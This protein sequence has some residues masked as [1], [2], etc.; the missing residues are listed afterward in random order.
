MPHTVP[1]TN[2]TAGRIHNGQRIYGRS[3]AVFPGRNTGRVQCIEKVSEY[4][5]SR[6]LAA[7]PCG[8]YE[9][10]GEQIY[11]SIQEYETK[12]YMDC[13]FETHK[14]YADIQCILQGKEQIWVT[15]Q[16]LPTPD[17]KYDPKADI[18]FWKDG[19][20]SLLDLHAGE[21]VILLPGEA[22]KPCVRS[23]GVGKVKKAVFKIAL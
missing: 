9:I 14:R 17:T 1:C 8:K 5:N 18:R 6:D 4:V 23:G 2:N 11:V 21:L 16:P 22:H 15:E 10:D 7:Q 19:K 20:A 13:R 3:A 12:S